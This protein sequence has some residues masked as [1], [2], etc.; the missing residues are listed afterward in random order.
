MNRENRKVGRPAILFGLVPSLLLIYVSFA[1]GQKTTKDNSELMKLVVDFSSTARIIKKADIDTFCG[2][3]D[4]PVVDNPGVV[5][6][7]FNGDKIKDFAVLLQIG[8]TV[9]TSHKFGTEEVSY[10]KVKVA[11]VAF[12]S[13]GNGKF[14]NVSLME[15]HLDVSNYPLNLYIRE[16]PAERVKE[17]EGFDSIKRFI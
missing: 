15:K 11:L 10:K 7:D 14:K 3:V 1:S 12:I 13:I 6:A 8:E 16:Q 2:S 4:Y 9:D 17:F 5:K